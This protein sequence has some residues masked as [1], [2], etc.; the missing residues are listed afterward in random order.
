MKVT[1]NTK[2]LESLAYTDLLDGEYAVITSGECWPVGS[3]VQ[4]RGCN[5]HLLGGHFNLVSSKTNR[6]RR[7]VAGE[8]ITINF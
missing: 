4:R 1:L 2:T 7:F 6:C 8:S 3:V 5:V